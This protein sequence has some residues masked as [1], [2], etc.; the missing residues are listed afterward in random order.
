MSGQPTVSIIIPTYNREKLLP[1]AV[2]SVLR[3]TFA[4]WEL[5]IIDDRSTDNTRQL[6]EDYARR[7]PR[8][9]YHVNGRVKGPSGARNQGIDLATGEYVAFLD[10]DDEWEP[11][12]LH[13]TVYY[14]RKYP[15]DIDLISANAVRKLRS[16]GEV[17]RRAEFD[18]SRYRHRQLEDAVCFEPE[19][20]FDTAMRLPIITTQT[21]VMRRAV[22]SQVRF[23]ESLPPGPE[24]AFFHL[25][26]A[27][28]RTK[29]AHLPRTHVTYWAHNG[30]LSCAGGLGDMRSKLPLF[31]AFE[32]MTLRTLQKFDLPAAQRTGLRGWLADLYFWY[33]GYNVYLMNHDPRCA[34]RYFLKAI[35]IKPFRLAFWKTFFLS[36][37]KRQALLHRADEVRS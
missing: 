2:E 20:L 13:D 11:H 21:M 3:Q 14:L 15:H 5:L 23:D 16:S 28:Q 34:R 6:V 19:T 37:V 29:V 4:D 25:E 8:V 32:Q 24:D 1:I 18:L 10:S 30:N 27:Y 9:K 7:D 12:H 22:L 31:L 36:F 33:I 35:R 26:L 17:Y